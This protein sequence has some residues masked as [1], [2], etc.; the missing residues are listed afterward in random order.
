MLIANPIY[1]VVFKY[2]LD[3]AEIARGLLSA[4]LGVEIVSLDVKPQ[5]TLVRD[6]AGEIKIFHLD[7]KAVINLAEGG[8]KTVLIELQKAKKSHDIIRFRTYLG[9]NY[10]KEEVRKNEKGEMESSAIEIVTIYILGFELKKV[11][12]PA[13][14]VSRKY[15]DAITNEEIFVEDDDFITKL[16]HESYTIQIPRLKHDQ[17]NQL[18]EV[19]EIFSQDFITDDL[20]NFEF[21]KD[22][23]NP[24][25]KK[26]VKRL[27][28]AAADKK[29]KR[30]MDAEDMIERL[31]NR[32][33]E[34]KLK[35][36]AEKYEKKLEEKDNV[37][38]ELEEEK[39]ESQDKLEKERKEN[40]EKLDKLEKE[41]QDKLERERKEYQDEMKVR[42]E[43]YAELARKFEEFLNKSN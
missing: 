32:E 27:S 38:T 20:H 19:L 13:L 36:Q 18:E 37:I 4:I 1:D 33:S 35:D 22:T 30:I 7:F 10:T 28:R 43:K 41:S 11:P 16:T 26:M 12:V 34:G 31:V 9:E 14:K 5:E 15:T 25:V 8:Q 24:L 29:I 6:E 2:L 23:Q 17:R 42:D 3:D 40:Q 39:K 21:K